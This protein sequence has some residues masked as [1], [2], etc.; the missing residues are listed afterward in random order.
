VI[1]DAVVQCDYTAKVKNTF[2]FSSTRLSLMGRV[3]IGAF[4]IFGTYSFTDV[5]RE[6]YG[7]GMKPYTIGLSLSGL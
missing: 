6:G 3:G 2:L 1:S 7:P 4:S 5:F